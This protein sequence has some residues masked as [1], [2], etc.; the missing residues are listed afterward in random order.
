MS[1]EFFL[2]ELTALG[3]RLTPEGDKLR[4]RGPRDVLT[5]E[6]VERMASMKPELLEALRQRRAARV[7]GS[8]SVEPAYGPDL[9]WHCSGSQ[10]CSCAL[11]GHGHVGQWSA[12]VCGACRG[13]GY[14]CW[15]R[16]N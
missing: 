16:I 7:R 4:Y 8:D 5:T 13:A 12:G 14:L 1:A 11:C 10:V 2:E 15:A 9:C 3:V 6:L